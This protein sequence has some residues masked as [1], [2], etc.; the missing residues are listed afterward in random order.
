MLEVIIKDIRLRGF[1]QD[2]TGDS[3]VLEELV[4]SRTSKYTPFVIAAQRGHVEQ[5]R[6][7]LA[8]GPDPDLLGFN[9][10]FQPIFDA[11]QFNRYSIVKL[12]LSHGVKLNR[13]HY[14]E[15]GN[16]LHTAAM[17][18]FH[19]LSIIHEHEICC[20]DPA[21]RDLE[22]YTLLQWFDNYRTTWVVEDETTRL[23]CREAFIKLLESVKIKSATTGHD[24]WKNRLGNAPRA[25]ESL[26]P[27]SSDD[28]EFFETQSVLDV[29]T[30]HL[31]DLGDEDAGDGVEE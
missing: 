15:N 25:N 29:D 24:C 23:Q 17:A 12:L 1:S 27:D 19:T 20:I 8:V 16:L 9:N 3:N 30:G 31:E 21:L 2:I 5:A 22:G 4:N 13:I 7:L 10:T 11:V 26:A 14:E 28:E 18:D 6:I